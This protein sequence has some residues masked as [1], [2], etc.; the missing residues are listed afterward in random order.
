MSDATK[1]IAQAVAEA[2]DTD[3]PHVAALA[4][5]RAG[6]PI[7]PCHPQDKT[8]LTRFGFKD[9]TTEPR[10]LS[11]WWEK[12]PNAMIGLRTGPESGVF[13]LDVDVDPEQ[14]IDGFIALAVLEQQHASLSET[15]R[16]V[17]PRGGSH[18]FFRWRHGIKNSASKLGA[19]LDIRGDG[20]YC[21]LPPSRRSDGRA[22]ELAELSATQPCEPPEWLVNLLILPKEKPAPS[23]QANHQID[24]NGNADAY[25]L[26]ALERECA[27]VAVARPGTRNEMLN[28]AAF[29]LGQLIAAGALAESEVRDRFYN[30]CV[31]NGLIH[32]DGPAAVRATIESG[33]NAGLKQPRTKYE[34]RETRNDG[35]GAAGDSN[36]ASAGKEQTRTN[37]GLHFTLYRDIERAPRKVWL[38]ENILGEGELSCMFGAPGCGKS[39]L[40]NDRAAHIAAGRPWFGRQVTRGGVL[41]VAA[42]RAA[43]GR[44]RFA[45]FRIHHALDDLPLAVVSGA[46]DLRSSHADADTIIGLARRLQDETGQKTV[47][48]DIDTV[49]RVLAGGDEN[50]SKDIGALIGN[51]TRI[52]EATGAH[53]SLVHHVPH[54][55]QRMRGHGA[56]LAACDVTVHVENTG[57][58]RTARVDKTND[59]ADGESL[60]FTFA[61]VELHRD[62]DTGQ[63]TEAPIVQPVDGATLKTTAKAKTAKGCSDRL[64]CTRRGHR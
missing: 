35:D 2:S 17:T 9:A 41:Y 56:L 53:I 23:P 21:I 30:A 47:L 27:A 7:F 44:R 20:G 62:L 28:R 38:V 1:R 49:S 46:I 43:L 39:V 57:A 32:D 11:R 34:A 52:Q 8:P 58:F 51:L 37:K 48:I 10:Q 36:R 24:G 40:A 45:A 59:G 15:L 4:Y 54:D 12:W 33:L 50:S 6:L 18:Y 14:N 61:T 5:A 19:G 64:A 26:A 25:A 13:V 60:A 3:S 29:S 42:E 63:L 16:S 31:A 22:Y 55:Q